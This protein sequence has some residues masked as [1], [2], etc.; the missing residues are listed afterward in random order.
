MGMRSLGQE[1]QRQAILF[2]KS[3]GWRNPG[4]LQSMNWVKKNGLFQR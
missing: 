4:T 3:P 1:A 2:S